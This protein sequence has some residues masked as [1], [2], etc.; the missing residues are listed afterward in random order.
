MRVL[1]AKGLVGVVLAVAAL[2]CGPRAGAATHYVSPG[3][4]A[5]GEGTRAK[6][7]SVS[8]V[9]TAGE[10]RAGDEVVFLDGVYKGG[11]SITTTGTEK[12]PIVYRAE[13]RHKAIIDGGTP[14]AGWRPVAGEKGVWA[15]RAEKAPQRLLVNGEGLIPASSRWRRDGK[16]TLDEGMFVCEKLEKDALSLEEK[17]GGVIVRIRPWAGQELKEVYA[18]SGTLVSIGGAYNVVDG[19]VIRRGHTGVHIKGKAVHTYKHEA[20]TYRDLAGLAHNAYGCYNVL[21]H[22]IVRDMVGQGMTTNESRFNLIEDCVIYNAGMGQGDHGIYVSQGAENLTLRRNIWWRTSGG[23][24][25]IYSGSGSDSPRN[26]VVERNIFGPDK[27]NRCFP[28]KNRKSCALYVWGGS[29]W[30]GH[31]RIVHNL[32]IGPH[33]RAISLHRCHF[34]L[35]AHNTFLGS[36]GAPIQIGNSMGNLIANNILEYAPGGQ[37]PGCQP[38]PTGYIHFLDEERAPG[39]SRCRNNLLLPRGEHGKAIPDW[40]ESSKLATGDP[41]VDRGRFDFRLK[42]DAGAIDLGIAIPNLVRQPQG[43]APDAGALELGDDIYGPKGRFPTI[44]QWLLDEWPLSK[45]GR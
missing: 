45:R 33:D 44:P 42:P 2:A 21:R 11:L 6:P 26:I 32:I 27:R 7:F 16:K 25:H 22:C 1:D 10:L 30:A 31:N 28:I 39:L 8:H 18:V 5:Q 20:G 15:C 14:L 23:A 4:S 12:A 9:L 41:F 37:E 35:I 3:G 19:F 17:R 38:H 34:N 40:M 24:I 13:N 43:K 36:D 29:R